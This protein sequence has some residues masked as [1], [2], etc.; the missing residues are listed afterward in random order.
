MCSHLDSGAQ[1]RRRRRRGRVQAFLRGDV[2]AGVQRRYPALPRQACTG[3]YDAARR[4]TSVALCNAAATDGC[5]YLAAAL[6]RA[7][8]VAPPRARDP[9]EARGAHQGPT[10]GAG[11]VS[12]GDALIG[13]ITKAPLA[14]LDPA[15]SR[16]AASFW[17]LARVDGLAALSIAAAAAAVAS[18]ITGARRHPR[19]RGTGE[20]SQN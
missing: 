9:A 8:G 5:P 18:A 1:C 6:G 7:I 10:V 17:Q 4:R 14:G 19:L 15:V 20:C 13:G 3:I 16:G 12:H 11:L 2:I